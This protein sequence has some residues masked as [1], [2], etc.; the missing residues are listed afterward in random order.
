MDTFSKTICYAI[1]V[2]IIAFIIRG[3]IKW[4]LT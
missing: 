3:L 4:F 2:G 1:L